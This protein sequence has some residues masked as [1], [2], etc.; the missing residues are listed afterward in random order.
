MYKL[1]YFGPTAQVVPLVLS[2]FRIPGRTISA[3]AQSASFADMRSGLPAGLV[4]NA[5]RKDVAGA[6]YF[7]K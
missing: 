1:A 5:N 2:S 4:Y 6:K 3:C 7:F